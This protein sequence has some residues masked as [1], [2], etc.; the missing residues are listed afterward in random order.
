MRAFLLALPLAALL[1]CG[2]SE[3]KQEDLGQDIS[4][5]YSSSACRLYSD[6]ACVRNQSDT[7]GWS[8]SFD[9]RGDCATFMW[10][11][12]L[13]C[14]DGLFQALWLAEDAVQACIDQMDAVDCDSD[15]ICPESGGSVFVDDACAEVDALMDEYCNS[16]DTG[17]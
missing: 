8:I 6:E 10:W 17:I 15:S 3:E 13:S 14:G 12:F 11:S 16:H 4:K 7:C 2:P 5:A 9:S 1:G